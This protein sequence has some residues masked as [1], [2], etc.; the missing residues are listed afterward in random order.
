[1]ELDAVFLSRLQ[2]AW[3]VAW[4][5]LLPAFT[6]GLASY[7]AVLE[8][9]HF[10]TGRDVFVRVSQFW[11]KIFAVSFGLGV[12]TGI[13]MP[14][15]FGTN[16]SRF[17][18][19]TADIISPLLAYEGLTAFF[20]EAAFL[21][22]LLFGRNRVPP[23][24][25]F[26]SALMVAIGTLFSSFW[27]LAVNSWMQTPVGHEIVDGRFLPVD[28]M[29]IIFSPSFPYRLAHTVVAFYVTAGFV[30]L[31]VGAYTLRRGRWEEGRVMVAMAMALL[32]V[33][34]PLQVLIGDL[35]G[36]NTLKHQP[37]KIAA[38]EAMWETGPGQPFTVFAIPDETAERNR[39]AIEI[40]K[41]G[42]LVLTHEVDGVVKG[43]KDWPRE[44]RPPV[45]IVFFAF[46]TMLAIG[47]AMLGLVA[48]GW[49]LRWRG[50]LYDTP[51]FLRLCEWFIPLGFVAILAGWTVTEVGRQPWTVY[52]LMRTAQSVT[53]S[54]TGL[55][56]LIS[57]LLYM[58]V[59]LL[60][61]P[62]ALIYIAR[63][64]RK[65]PPR[66][67]EPEEESPVESGRPRLP[68]EALPA[69][70]PGRRI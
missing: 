27:I 8:G 5:I 49:I 16:W 45:A 42:S 12:V 26:F 32:T 36:L 14:F 39:V 54:L 4:H 19:A 6:V 43:L 58:V 46:R 67:D 57:L 35:H 9:I 62:V 37:A 40:P 1:M 10:V 41:A 31:G 55:D 50:R 17:T 47:F 66:A 21:G 56:V 11:I 59:Y 53:P 20:L 23:A 30:V 70:S 65:G 52:G 63:I 60:V 44:D 22:V 24:I 2:V 28:W 7:I 51:W 3:V 61:Y 33:L 25:H 68:V 18:D 15:Q 13:V 38:M 64:V 69:G 48:L 34:V 29:Q